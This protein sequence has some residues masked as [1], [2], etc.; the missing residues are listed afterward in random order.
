[1]N[2]DNALLA[3]NT[4]SRRSFLKWSIG[5]LAALAAL[6]TVGVTF[7]Y[8][9]SQAAATEFIGAVRAGALGDF[10]PGSVTEF[11]SSGFYLIRAHDGGFLALCR[12]CPHLG[13]IVNWEHSANA[14][15]CPCHAS[16]F[17]S[18]GNF[19]SPPVSRSLDRFTVEIDG[20]EVIVDT[21]RVTRRQQFD[22]QELVY[23][24]S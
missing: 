13:C 22:P 20:D 14:F 9:Q 12:R 23:A 7:F 21:S 11:V 8:L 15:Y 4:I 18:V 24:A 3:P 10:P 5:G 19:Q 1:M 2:T 16:H 17:D 6:E